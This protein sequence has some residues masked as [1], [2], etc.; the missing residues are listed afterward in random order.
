[1]KDEGDKACPF[2]SSEGCILYEDRPGACRIYPIGRAATKPDGKRHTTERFFIVEEE[3]CLGFKEEKE[4]VLEEW[5]SSEG[6]DKYNAMND[7]WME[8]I[9]SSNSLGD[10]QHVQKKIQMFYM[11]SYNL[12]RFREFLFQSAFFER[13]VIEPTEKEAL[14]TDDIKLM[15]FAVKWLKFSLFGEKTIQIKEGHSFLINDSKKIAPSR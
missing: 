5:L 3:H 14:A 6:V 10:E 9:T 15:M 4:W 11:A 8:I 7:P 1:M 12:D 13:F 2:V